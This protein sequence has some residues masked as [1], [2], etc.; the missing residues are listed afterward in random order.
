MQNAFL[1]RVQSQTFR[2]RLKAYDLKLHCLPTNRDIGE[3]EQ[4]FFIALH[5]SVANL[6]SDTIQ[7][8]FGFC[9]KNGAPD[10]L[11]QGL[12]LNAYRK[13]KGQRG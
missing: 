5:R 2:L 9:I 6:Y 10:C 4:A 3:R 12:G 7:W 13:E 1:G 8:E 11:S